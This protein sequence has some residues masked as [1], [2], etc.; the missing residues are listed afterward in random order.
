MIDSQANRDII[1]TLVFQK[2]NP[3]ATPAP[4]SS[5]MH[6]LYHSGNVAQLARQENWKRTVRVY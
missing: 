2:S 5:S 4:K 1:I 3:V 6:V